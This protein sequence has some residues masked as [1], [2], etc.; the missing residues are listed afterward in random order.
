MRRRPFSNRWLN[1]IRRRRLSPLT[2]RILA[3]N[4]LPLAMLV[5]GVFYLDRHHD[6]LIATRLN[7]LGVEA[8]MIAGAI[9]LGAASPESGKFEFDDSKLEPIIRRLVSESGHRIRLFGLDG[10]LILDSQSLTNPIGAP[11]ATE[12]PPPGFHPIEMIKQFGQAL[13]RVGRLID[14]RGRFKRYQENIIQNAD[15]YPESALALEG[16]RHAS[17]RVTRDGKLILSA[18]VP[19]QRLRRILGAVML[20]LDGQEILSEV[21]DQRIV[22]LEVFLVTIAVTITLSLFLASTISRPV[23]RLARAAERIRSSIKNRELLPAF[24]Q[25]DDEIGDLARALN[26]MTAALYSRLD[27]IEAFAADV[28]HEIKNPLTSMKSALETLIDTKQPERRKL[29]MEIL[30]NDIDRL[31]RLITDIA[32]SSKVDA[33]MNRAEKETIDLGNFIKHVV[34]GYAHLRDCEAAEI[35]AMTPTTPVFVAVVPSRLEQ[36]FNNLIDNA[37]SFTPPDGTISISLLVRS[38]DLVVRVD[39]QGPGIPPSKLDTIFDRFYSDRPAA[40][41]DLSFTSGPSAGNHS[42]L[43][44]SICRQIIEAHGGQI[45]AENLTDGKGSIAGARFEFT[46]PQL[47]PEISS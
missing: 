44:L 17:A 16:Q 26:N 40:P 22:I 20:S 47:E 15:D 30:I 4:L 23:I 9:A 31:D 7:S 32:E 45:H 33:E 5:V 21:R 34:E 18:G 41:M 13:G 6:G 29:L 1:A 10:R 36:V 24:G 28:S 43:G 19:V 42:G 35:V 37:L 8:Q 11:T 25:R 27:T 3:V 14:F 46:L 12:L 2:R 38:E 39:D